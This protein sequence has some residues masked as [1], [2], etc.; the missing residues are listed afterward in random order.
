MLNFKNFKV[1]FFLKVYKS[2]FCCF[3]LGQQFG[4]EVR[5]CR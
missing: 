5:P 1:N 3:R 2:S 4:K